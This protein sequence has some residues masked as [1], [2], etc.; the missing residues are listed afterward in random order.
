MRA[1]RK[2]WR[3]GQSVR[4]SRAD[5]DRPGTERRAGVEQRVPEVLADVARDQDLIG[6]DTQPVEPD[7]RSP[8]PARPR[9]CTQRRSGSARSRTSTCVAARSRSRL[10]GPATATM[11]R[12]DVRSVAWPQTVRRRRDDHRRRAHEE[13][14]R[15]RSA[16]SNAPA[17]RCWRPA[18]PAPREATRAATRRGRAPARAAGA[19][20]SR[21]PARPRSR[22]RAR[23]PGRRRTNGPAPIGP[24]AAGARRRRAGEV[25]R[26]AAEGDRHG[27]ARMRAPCGS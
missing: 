4:S 11:V 25:E 24:P 10:R 20:R 3:I 9:S 14:A 23:R 6:G 7:R 15:R 8:A 1:R 21:R 27:H 19:A 26:G 12:P 16:G 22:A 18:P 17:R 5:A 2:S 13:G